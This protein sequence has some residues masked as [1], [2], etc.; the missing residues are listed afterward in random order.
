MYLRSKT[1]LAPEAVK[2]D[3]MWSTSKI[4]SEFSVHYHQD[5]NIQR[6]ETVESLMYLYR[7]TKD[8]IYRDYGYLIMDAFEVQSKVASGGYRDTRNVFTGPIE[9]FGTN[10]ES[11]FLA[12]TLKYL[13]LLFSDDDVLPL[14]G[15]VFNTEAHPFPVLAK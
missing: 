10:M 4:D 12:E 1:K 3:N 7:V 6:P 14:D 2:F 11:F 5:Y 15:V 9:T 13:F 8:P